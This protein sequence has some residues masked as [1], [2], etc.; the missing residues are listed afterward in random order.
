MKAFR[1][2]SADY[3]LP[4]RAPPATGA[5]LGPPTTRAPVD[6]EPADSGFASAL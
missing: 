5:G 4:A 6:Y 3:V 1:M 2:Y